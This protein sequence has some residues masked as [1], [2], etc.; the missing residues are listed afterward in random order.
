M[1][2]SA[3]ML[4]VLGALLGG[5]VSP[6]TVRWGKRS[7]MLLAVGVLCFGIPVPC[8]S[9]E[10]LA[11]GSLFSLT[12]S[13]TA[14]VQLKHAGRWFDVASVPKDVDYGD[15]VKTPPEVWAIIEIYPVGRI[16]SKQV[17]N[18]GPDSEVS[19]PNQDNT[20]QL[21]K[22]WFHFLKRSSEQASLIK[23]KSVLGAALKTDFM[24][25]VDENGATVVYVASG[26]IHLTNQVDTMVLTNGEAAVASGGT[27][28]LE[29]LPRLDM[30]V[31]RMVQTFLYYPGVLNLEDLGTNLSANPNLKD[32]VNAY[33]LG[34]LPLALAL[35][36]TNRAPAS[37][38][39]RLYLASLVLTVGDYPRAQSLLTNLAP[40]EADYA[41]QKQLAD[42]M[43][44]V[45][46]AAE[47]MEWPRPDPPRSSTAWL[48]ESYYQQSRVGQPYQ[49]SSWER[50]AYRNAQNARDALER[51]LIAAKNATPE[52]STFGFGWV[53]RAELE[54]SFGRIKQ[55][56][57]A[58]A[59]VSAQ[60]AGNA[61]A[62]A[63][64][65]FL[66]WA[67]NDYT[68]ALARFQEAAGLD[69]RL[70]N[71][72]LGIGL[73]EL[74]QENVFEYFRRGRPWD[75]WRARPDSEGLRHLETATAAEPDRSLLRSYLGKAYYDSSGWW[76]QDRH[77]VTN[78]FKQ[79]DLAK[80]MDTNDPTP[81]LYSAL[82]KQ[83]ENQINEAV[84]D[85]EKS[86]ALNANRAVFRSRFLL[87]EDLAVRSANLA[88]IYRDA[89]MTDV[90]VREASRAATYDYANYSA[91]L[92]LSDS[93]NELRDPTRFNL[94]FETVWFNEL[95]LANLLSPVGGGRL[96]QHVSQQEYSKLF[97]ADGL[98]LA[99]STVARTDGVFR[100]LASQYGTFGGTSYALDLDYQNN[101]GVRPNNELDS[102]EWYSTVKQQLTP[103]DTALLLVKYEDYHSGDNFQYYD[104]DRQYRP[105]FQFD[106]YQQPI[107][108]GGWHHEWSP[109]MHTLFLGG[110]L[111][112]DQRFSDRAAQRLLLIPAEPYRSDLVPF[113]VQYHGKLEIYT[114][115]LNQIFQRNWLTLSAGARYQSGTFDTTAH[116]YNPAKLS[117]FFD[118]RATNAMH[119]SD[120]FER[121]TGYGYLTVQPVEQDRKST[122]LN[123][124]QLGI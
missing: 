1:M 56:K 103:Q 73:T 97:E 123:S 122:R 76:G 81:Y 42:A 100:E 64:R 3:T 29:R 80:R 67:A 114:A 22:G 66:A 46:A 5:E 65:G 101:D 87:D 116:L 111:E 74:H 109:G 105:H 10:S 20:W 124:S 63:L 75:Y 79:L 119:E 82:I 47:G 92:F 61:Q 50:S 85:L 118:G 21:I 84:D 91:H 53:R 77:L 19:I 108:V 35:Y 12:N 121:I 55:A 89:G 41:K 39:G 14:Y 9:A 104:P 88:G 25:H 15:T 54:F 8:F 72:W 94:R 27:N 45:M 98:H 43:Q 11:A 26:E 40:Q 31:R 37:N 30:R 117:G 102:I 110:R 44:Q 34:N 86:I 112:N 57:E 52:G 78:A 48:A 28:K 90:S 93:Y 99:N 36:P 38:A 23:T 17:V 106:E 107:A 51:A 49:P 33:S 7:H 68:N 13:A 69:G 24:V 71:A 70:G 83:Q 120:G 62:V 4:K 16:K 2:N 113:D 58:L 59:K 115:E 6:D 96:S 32:S 18:M 95:L 60:Q